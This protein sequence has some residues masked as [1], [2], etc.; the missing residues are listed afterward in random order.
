MSDALTDITTENAAEEDPHGRHRGHIAEDEGQ[1][2][3]PHGRHRRA[4]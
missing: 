3:N 2:A 4:E 1:E